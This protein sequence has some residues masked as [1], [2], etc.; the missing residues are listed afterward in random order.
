M[1]ILLFQVV[2]ELYM[3]IVKHSQAHQV[4]THLRREGGN[5]RITVE[6][7]GIGFDP[8]A[9]GDRPSF[10]FFSIRERLKYLGGRLE[11]QAAPEKGTLIAVVS[12]LAPP[13][14]AREAAP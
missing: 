5:L 12:P 4:I 1:S 9:I 7:D 8:A 13:I 6:D 14:P 10:G 2:R 11:I 3:N